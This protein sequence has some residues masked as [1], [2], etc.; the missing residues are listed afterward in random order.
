MKKL[1][2]PIALLI[3]FFIF[4]CKEN[5]ITETEL[6]T[7]ETTAKSNIAIS[8]NQTVL[9]FERLLNDPHLVGNSFYKILGNIEYQIEEKTTRQNV[10]LMNRDVFVTLDL[11]ADLKYFC[12]VCQPSTTDELTGFISE[13]TDFTI[14]TMQNTVSLLHK[15]FPVQGCRS[16]MVLNV[17][18]CISCSKIELLS[19]WLSLSSSDNKTTHLKINK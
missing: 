2:M 6:E 15:I 12:S 1:F 19:M 14:S 17:Q 5:S 13:E 9:K 4:G 16:N 8:N 18:L 3:L 7:N 11:N 10:D